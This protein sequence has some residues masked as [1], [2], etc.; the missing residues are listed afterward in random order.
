EIDN[1]TA[2]YLNTPLD[3]QG[4]F[5]LITSHIQVSTSSISLQTAIITIAQL[6]NNLKEFYSN[7]VAQKKVAKSKRSAEKE[8]IELEFLYNNS[9]NIQY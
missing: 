5:C 9:S 2:Q 1:I 6:S 7:V 3:I 8:L 4:I